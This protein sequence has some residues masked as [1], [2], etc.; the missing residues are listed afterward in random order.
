MKHRKWN[1]I[2]CTLAVSFIFSLT[3]CGSSAN[4]A[5]QPEDTDQSVN[6]S[7]GTVNIGQ[8]EEEISGM[9]EEESEGERMGS[10]DGNDIL[11]V[12]FTAAEKKVIED[13]FTV[14][15]RDVAEADEDVADWLEGLGF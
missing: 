8:S 9:Q 13:G 2:F 4:R 10:A 14:S 1:I 6:R 15:E 7:E 12:Y 5:G 3:G 11:I